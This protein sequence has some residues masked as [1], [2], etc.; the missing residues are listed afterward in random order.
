[1]FDEKD[2]ELQAE[3]ILIVDPAGGFT[4]A[5]FDLLIFVLV[6]LIIVP[7]VIICIKCLLVSL[8]FLSISIYPTDKFYLL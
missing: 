5:N 4:K 1:V 7:S 2:V 3:N 8:N 6:N